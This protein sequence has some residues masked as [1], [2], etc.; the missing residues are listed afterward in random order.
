MNSRLNDVTFDNELTLKK[1]RKTLNLSSYASHLE[2]L[3]EI[4]R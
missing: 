3:G 4:Q 2:H 1:S